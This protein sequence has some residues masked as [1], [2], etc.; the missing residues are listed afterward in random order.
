[1]DA[2]REAGGAGVSIGES[3]A[4]DIDAIGD[5]PLPRERTR[6][7]GHGAAESAFLA[8]AT[9]GRLH[10]AWLLTG[11]EG[12]GKATFA[13][14]AARTLLA[15]GRTDTLD[16]PENAPVFRRV[17][18]L[19]HPDLFVLRRSQT[20]EGKVRT[21]TSVDDVRDLLHLFQSTSGAQGWRVAI[22][23]PADDMNRN[24][25][26]ALLK[27]LEEPPP[28]AIFLIVSHDPARLL[29]TIRSR[30]RRLAFPA[31]G[32]DDLESIV[33]ELAPDA[34]ATLRA[35]ALARAGGSARRAL[36]LIV[37]GGLETIQAVEAVLNTLPKLDPRAAN[38]LAERVAKR[39]AEAEHAL[40]LDTV[41]AW[42]QA[43]VR[44]GVRRG[45]P[46]GRLAALGERHQQ[47]VSAQGIAEAY[48]LDRKR[49]VLDALQDLADATRAAT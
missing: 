16:T 23:D 31:L 9:S 44:A 49:A 46:L 15:G 7:V 20:K 47:G 5:L 35:E 37:D 18:N 6:L 3:L 48:N 39:G 11:P 12:V 17:A 27:M 2:R 14:R 30:C 36:S 13:Y 1:M 24:A 25:S 29:P 28:R 41:A 22:V 42:V 8:A 32:R 45:E 19:A 33:G 38:A 10:H 34:D 43:R 40:F 21:E 26:N 4:E